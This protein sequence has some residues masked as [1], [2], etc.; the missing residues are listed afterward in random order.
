MSFFASY[1]IRYQIDKSLADPSF[2]D[3]VLRSYNWTGFVDGIKGGSAQPGANAKQ[4]ASFEFLLPPLPE[5]KAIAEVLSSLD[6]KIDLLHR[7]NKTLESMAET[8]FRKWFI[9]DAK[10]DWEEDKLSAIAIFKNG[11]SR[12]KE[13]GDYP[14]YGGNGIL[15]YSNN[16][17]A[18]D[19]SIIIG[20]VGAYCG[21]L[22]FEN[23]KIWVSDN[24]IL[25]KAKN[26]RFLYFLFYFL[27]NL[28][29]NDLAEG[30]SHPLLTQTLLNKIDVLIPSDYILE[31]FKNQVQHCFQKTEANLGQIRTL[32]RLRDTLLPRLMSGEVRVNIN[33]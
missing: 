16:F 6:D 8:L 14:V 15:G 17:N 26:E 1:L 24:A 27:K 7:Q 10:E 9:E 12:P 25:V 4:F 33:E 3:F 30:S 13:N 5:Q 29:L 19:E 31:Q 11:K 18:D 23:Q 21:S 2:V 22:Y 32:E 20:R 28:N